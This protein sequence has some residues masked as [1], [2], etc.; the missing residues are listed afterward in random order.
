VIVDAAQGQAGG[1]VVELM[2]ARASVAE[3]DAAI[4]VAAR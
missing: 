3:A 2:E 4:L 1:V